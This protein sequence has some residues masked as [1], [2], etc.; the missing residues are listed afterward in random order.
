MAQVPLL[1]SGEYCCYY[2]FQKSRSIKIL[3]ISL[4]TAKLIG[5]FYQ[6][7]AVG[8]NP[9]H[10]PPKAVSSQPSS[11]AIQAATTAGYNVWRSINFSITLTENYR[12]HANPQW[13]SILRRLRSLT[14]TQADVDYIN[15]TCFTSI[16]PPVT[17]ATFCPFLTSSNIYKE[18]FIQQTLQSFSN[19]NS[20]PIHCFTAEYRNE[21]IPPHFAAKPFHETKPL[22]L[23]SYVVV[24]MPVMV[25]TNDKLGRFSNGTSGYVRRIE[26]THSRPHYQQQGNMRYYT[27]LPQYVEIQTFDGKIL[28]IPPITSQ[29]FVD[30]TKKKRSVKNLPLV[31]FFASTIDK[32]QGATLKS[33]ILHTAVTNEFRKTVPGELL[34]V[35]FSR[36]ENPTFIRL[37]DPISLQQIL[38]LRLNKHTRSALEFLNQIENQLH[39]PL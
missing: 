34:Y 5:D 20:E 37:T 39:L 15:A 26:F 27:S 1:L 17:P 28:Q 9:I 8:S 7:P 2:I 30:N 19:L 13:V 16:P 24:G 12:H 11:F 6:L 21:P 31:P 38:Q 29:V 33:C 23:T 18:S 36:C 25:T 35:L 4:F 22:P 3:I 10:H 32:M 14:P